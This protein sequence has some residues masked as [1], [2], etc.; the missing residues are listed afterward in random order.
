MAYENHQYSTAKVLLIFDAT[1][2]VPS[3][4][5]RLP[6]RVFCTSPTPFRDCACVT[7]THNTMAFDVFATSRP[8]S[9][10]LSPSPGVPHLHVAHEVQEQ[11][12]EEAWAV[13]Q[14]TRRIFYNV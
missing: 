9:S 12:P 10:F 13:F 3:R 2:P 11:P 4:P 14:H 5:A 1:P 8:R 6:L 7:A